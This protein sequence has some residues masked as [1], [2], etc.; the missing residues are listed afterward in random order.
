MGGSKV[1]RS[2]GMAG[3][4]LVV[5]CIAGYFS[6][7]K[8]SRLLIWQ[9]RRTGT[10][11]LKCLSCTALL[12]LSKVGFSQSIGLAVGGDELIGSDSGFFGTIGK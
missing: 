1:L 11:S 2:R 5:L 6:Q 12:R 7:Y 8:Y 10:H 9:K 4:I 3:F